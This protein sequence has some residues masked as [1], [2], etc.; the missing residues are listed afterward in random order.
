[1]NKVD[2]S[3]VIIARN[4]ENNLRECLESCSFAKEI[5]LVDDN[6]T[7]KTVE[8]AKEFG[9]KVYTRSLEGNWGAQQ[10]FAI[11]KATCSWI[12]LIDADERCSDALQNKIVDLVNK[13]DKFTYVIKRIT[14]L[15]HYDIGHGPLRP[16]YVIRLMPNDGA[17]VDGY[18]HPQIISKYPK[19]NIKEHIIHYSYTDWDQYYRKMNQ[20]G[21]LAT[22][23]YYKNGKKI[24]FAA[25]IYKPVWAFIKVYFLNLGILD[26]KMGYMLAANHAAYTL[27]KYVRLY[28]LEKTK[29]LL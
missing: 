18:V 2:V 15:R 17:R 22:D 16:D 8:I 13:N 21:K 12:F 19:Q 23:K 3:I 6:S 9:A 14:K 26:G 24:S 5:I 29:G 1:M 4:E 11:D 28:T 27:Q 20:Y 7:D 25:V 10:T